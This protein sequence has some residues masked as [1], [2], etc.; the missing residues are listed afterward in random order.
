MASC[1]CPPSDS[2]LAVEDGYICT[3]PGKAHWLCSGCVIRPRGS[4]AIRCR[5]HYASVIP[6]GRLWG[7]TRLRPYA[8]AARV[9]PDE[10]MLPNL[11]LATVELVHRAARGAVECR[12]SFEDA[13]DRAAW[14]RPAV[15]KLG[16]DVSGM[17]ARCVN[18]LFAVVWPPEPPSVTA[19]AWMFPTS[20]A[21]TGRLANMLPATEDAVM[22]PCSDPGPTWWPAH[23]ADGRLLGIDSALIENVLGSDCARRRWWFA[24]PLTPPPVRIPSR[25]CENDG[26]AGRWTRLDPGKDCDVPLYAFPPAYETIII[27]G[28]PVVKC[29]W[30][31]ETCSNKSAFRA[32]CAPD[33]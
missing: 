14:N 23:D 4:N 7:E 31:R 13:G 16:V 29:L 19:T 30:C 28:E 18:H 12:V 6:V 24:C 27:R 25:G 11:A 15:L 8:M 20:T 2:K 32:R 26:G 3:E 10:C 9:H 17:G 5:L 1:L 33:L 21:G 22:L